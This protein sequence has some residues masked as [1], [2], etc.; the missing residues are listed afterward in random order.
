[1]L[2]SHSHHLAMQAYRPTTQS[3]L[4]C[5][6]FKA[7]LSAQFWF[8]STDLIANLFLHSGLSLIVAVNT[9]PGYPEV[10]ASNYREMECD[11]AAGLSS[12]SIQKAEEDE[13]ADAHLQNR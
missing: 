11:V 13:Q 9:D 1:M 8:Y 3:K 12:P 2:T 7:L 10:L 6:W 4:F 5:D